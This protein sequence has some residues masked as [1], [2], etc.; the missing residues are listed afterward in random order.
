MLGRTVAYPSSPDLNLLWSFIQLWTQHL[1]LTQS[2]IQSLHLPDSHTQHFGRQQCYYAMSNCFINL[3]AMDILYGLDSTRRECM[4]TKCKTL[5]QGCL[6]YSLTAEQGCKA[7]PLQHASHCQ[8]IAI[9]SNDKTFG[10]NLSLGDTN[11]GCVAFTLGQTVAWYWLEPCGQQPYQ[12]HLQALYATSMA[13]QEWQSHS[14][15]LDG[16]QQPFQHHAAKQ[17]LSV[18]LLGWQCAVGQTKVMDL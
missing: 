14:C 8:Q 3:T 6:L 7:C 16:P 9:T 18:S 12:G 2:T 15:L 13:L 1:L 10:Y 11:Q 5:M 4:P 17:S